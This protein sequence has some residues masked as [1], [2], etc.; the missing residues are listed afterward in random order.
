MDQDVKVL[1]ELA[2]Q[3]FAYAMSDENRRKMELH[4]SLI[5]I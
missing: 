2:S 5:H 4:L 1:R 3:Y